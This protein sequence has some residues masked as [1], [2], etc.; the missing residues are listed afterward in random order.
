MVPTPVVSLVPPGEAIADSEAAQRFVVVSAGAF[1]LGVRLEAVLE[2]LGPRPCT[3]LPGAPD[4]VIGLVNLR[5]RMVT[6]VDL[7]RRMGGTPGGDRLVVVDFRGRQVAL[8][9]DDVLRILPVLPADLRPAREAAA[10]VT[11]TGEGEG[12]MFQALDTDT[13]LQPLFG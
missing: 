6:V 2:V 11:H 13:L 12:V 7:S 9:V 8:A 3:P 10:F 5:G 4:S 1:H